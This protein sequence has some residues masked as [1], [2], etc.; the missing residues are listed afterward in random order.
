ML[1]G[2]GQAI[3]AVPRGLLVVTLHGYL[4]RIRDIIKGLTSD[5]L[6]RRRS[7]RRGRSGSSAVRSWASK[8]NGAASEDIPKKPRYRTTTV[9]PSG[10]EARKRIDEKL[11]RCGQ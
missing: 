4:K 5:A 3:E 10:V 2:Q 11:L 9:M 6:A 1:P 7:G 8:Q